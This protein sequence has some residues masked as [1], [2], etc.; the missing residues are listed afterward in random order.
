M[1]LSIEAPRLN[2]NED[3]ILVVQVMARDGQAVARDELLFVVETT[4]AA[5]EV[6]AA[7]AGWV[8]GLEVRP[9]EMVDVGSVLCVVEPAAPATGA[10]T[11]AEGAGGPEGVKVTLK[12]RRRAAELGVRL[13]DVRAEGG[14]VG[15]EQVER[16]VGVGVSAATSAGAPP[17]APVPAS[18][19]E[20]GC[21]V[22][23][24]GG[25][26][27]CVIDL[28]LG[29]GW[30]IVGCTSRDRDAG[31]DVVAGV[32]V[33]EEAST[34]E[35]L[36]AT[37]AHTAFVGVGGTTDNEPRRRLYERLVALGFH[38][39]PVVSA[40]A[41]IGVGAVIGPA[42]VVF[43]GAV[44]G[45]RVQIGAN[46]IVNAGAVVCHDSTVGDHCHLTPGSLVAGEC[47]IGTGTTVG[48]AATLLNRTEIG[49]GCLIHNGAAVSGVIPDDTELTAKGLRTA[50]CRV[51]E[52]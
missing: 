39:P 19:G 6:R 17:P 33:L 13:E 16:H 38:L 36:L 24:A 20:A 11:A 49:A 22:V 50:R 27:A 41:T 31:R 18:A 32:R 9:G 46:C 4:K 5:S 40:R 15:V 14:R 12:A 52:T 44:V 7:A 35:H 1:S 51:A 42:T 8:R 34:L 48:M 21:V 26:A 45:P 23:G 28:L 25:H 37:G 47:R 10:A 30:R 43:P 29:S 3:Q 2:A